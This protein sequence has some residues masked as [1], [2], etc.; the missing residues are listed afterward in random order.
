VE[1]SPS[2]D[3]RL[4]E[5][6]SRT[7]F[8][9]LELWCVNLGSSIELVRWLDGG[10]TGAK[11]AVV[12]L[13]DDHG[14]RQVVLKY[15]PSLPDGIAGDYRA[16]VAAA[17]S[18]PPD[19]AETHL[20]G[21]DPWVNAPVINGRRGLFLLMGWRSSGIDH[22]DALATLLDRDALGPACCVVA[23]SILT[24]WNSRPKS[25]RSAKLT[26][27]EFLR[28][29]V[30]KRCEPGG[31]VYRMA[32]RLGMPLSEPTV[33]FRG[34]ETWRN[35]FA[36]VST[37]DGIRHLGYTS[38]FRGNAHGD[39]HA[40]NILVPKPPN[41]VLGPELF[42]KY[43]LIDLSTFGSARLLTV[44]PIHLLLSIIGR[45]FTALSTE[46]RSRMLDMVLEP[47]TAERGGIPS[48]LA[49][50]A[51]AIRD[52]ETAFADAPGRHLYDDWQRER[53]LAIAGCALVFIGRRLPYVD[54]RWWFLELAAR[55][56]IA[57][58]GPSGG[59][60]PSA[61]SGA[62]KPSTV[63][64]PSTADSPVRPG[65]GR[66]LAKVV[67]LGYYRSRTPRPAPRPALLPEAV[68]ELGRAVKAFVECIESL[69][70]L[71]EMTS[72]LAR[73]KLP[74]LRARIQSILDRVESRDL[75]DLPPRQASDLR[76]AVDG[77]REHVAELPGTPA[78]RQER[79]G[80][81]RLLVRGLVARNDDG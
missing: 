73:L 65:G 33:T 75:A 76:Y 37:G 20:V 66:D 21:L 31:S 28:E 64:D 18:G 81:L 10:N 3:Q 1:P 69:E 5:R 9:A 48:E 53:L 26:V 46:G 63:S 52:A 72:E 80:Q 2:L 12:Q 11:V 45:R 61:P 23:T 17:E 51:A 77:I 54:A 71:P 8:G 79:V 29:V 50:A 38:G 36:A 24:D 42:G 25:F 44:D 30:G 70:F 6:L 4:H 67:D 35:P 41:A 40:D 19:F 60:G 59:S 55:A 43:V 58:Q 13:Q 16:F 57:Y 62:S 74:D 22:Y 7:E 56:L 68:G 49:A 34:G 27:H 32:T 78:D 39:L 14:P 15:C 47:R